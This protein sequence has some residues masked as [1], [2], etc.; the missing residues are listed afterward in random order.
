[1]GSTTGVTARICNGTL[2]CCNWKDKDY[3][4]FQ[5]G[6][7]EVN[8]SSNA[9]KEFVIVSKKQWTAEHQQASNAEKGDSGSF[10]IN[11]SG[12]ICGLLYSATSGLY[13]PP[14]QSHFYIN[15]GFAIDF[16]ELLD[17]LRLRTMANNANGNMITLPSELSLPGGD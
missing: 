15:A 6:G 4:R 16:T 1:M 17:S 9:T 2:E 5:H 11:N 10:V 12:Q 3:V 14:N 8:L 7:Q 13:N